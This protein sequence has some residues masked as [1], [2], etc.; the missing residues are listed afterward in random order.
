MRPVT[1]EDVLVALCLGALSGA[2]VVSVLWAVAWLVF[3]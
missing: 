2:F 1:R 3:A